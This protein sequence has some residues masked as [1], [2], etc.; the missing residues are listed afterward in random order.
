[1]G[2]LQELLDVQR[3][4]VPDPGVPVATLVA[5]GSA[6]LGFQQLSELINKP[7]IEIVGMLPPEV[8]I[9]TIFS[10]A[11]GRT[12]ER[13][14]I[15]RDLLRFMADPATAPVKRRYGMDGMQDA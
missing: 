7:G 11:I 15:A 10:G 4:K 3:I 6:A 5:D 14:D 13:P 9:V 12:S 1:M 8:E 2:I